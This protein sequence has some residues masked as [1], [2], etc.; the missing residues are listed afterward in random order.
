MVGNSAGEEAKKPFSGYAGQTGAVPA[1]SLGV[2]E[3]RRGASIIQSKESNHET[4]F[5]FDRTLLVYVCES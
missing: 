3:R 5:M 4:V 2:T 1:S